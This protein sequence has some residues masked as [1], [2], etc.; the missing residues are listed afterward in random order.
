MPPAR[1]A[2][3]SSEA[4]LS[5]FWSRLSIRL[6]AHIREEAHE[7]SLSARAR[8][9][10]PRMSTISMPA[11]V[12]AAQLRRPLEQ[13]RVPEQDGDGHPLVQSGARGAQDESPRSD[14]GSTTRCGASLARAA[15]TSIS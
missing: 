8:R 1:S 7:R 9:L 6:L 12:D 5:G 11:E 2:A 14:S 13:E 15:R 4:T 10:G 3:T